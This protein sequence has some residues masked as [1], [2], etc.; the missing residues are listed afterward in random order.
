MRTT[1]F[2]L[3]L[4]VFMSCTKIDS[5][6]S[7]LLEMSSDPRSEAIFATMAVQLKTHGG[8]D[9]V[10][11]LLNQLVDDSKKQLHDSNKLFKATD[12]R[13]EVDTARFNERQTYYENK[14]SQLSD[15]VAA[16]NEEK[17]YA[18]NTLKALGEA[19][20]IAS[21][22]LKNEKER[23][24]ED[25][26]LYDERV[27]NAKAAVKHAEDAIKAVGEW[28]SSSQTSFVQTKLNT[29]TESYLQVKSFHLV[30]P[31]S[32][33]QLA[34][35]DDQVKNRLEEWLASLRLTLLEAQSD[36]EATLS[37]HQESWDNIEKSTQELI[38]EYTKDTRTLKTDSEVFET[39]A[40]TLSQSQEGVVALKD[41]NQGLVDANKNYCTTERGNYEA[42]KKNIEEQIKLFKEIRTYFRG[43]YEKIN[44]FVKDKYNAASH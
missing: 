24:Q 5:Y 19:E 4:L 17:T 18:E 3:T 34:A 20:T 32:F 26:A 40:S 7:V 14:Y 36:M 1:I 10:I 2:F 33:V 29:L 22:F 35:S 9:R 31:Q 15:L 42:A 23:H 28:N 43:N 44:Q 6:D 27:S 13:C 11:A 37:T 16:A 21:T 30:I 25:R 12:A 41:Q 8:F 38:D 39:T